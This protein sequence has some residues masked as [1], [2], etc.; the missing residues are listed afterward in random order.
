MCGTDLD[1]LLAL[2]AEG[3]LTVLALFLMD[4]DLLLSM[5]VPG[6]LVATGL[7]PPTAFMTRRFIMLGVIVV[8]LGQTC[9]KR[10]GRGRFPPTLNSCRIRSVL[11]NP[12]YGS[13][14]YL[15]LVSLDDLVLVS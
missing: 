5:L 15:R 4:G 8:L 1:L 9:P 12:F 7:A 13:Y 10:G 2:V 3:V 11:C 14:S 6:L